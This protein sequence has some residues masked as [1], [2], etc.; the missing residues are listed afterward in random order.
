MPIVTVDPWMELRTHTAARIALG[1]TGVS[2]PTHE[3]LRFGYAHAE[4]RDAVYTPLDE[5][6]LREALEGDGWTTV[7]VHSAA[8]DR[9]TYLARPD[10]GRQLDGPSEE[11]LGKQASSKHEVLLVVGDGLSSA[12]IHR[13]AAPFLRALRKHAPAKFCK[14]PVVIARQAR[15]ALGDAI[16]EKLGAKLVAVL[17]GERP[18]LSSPDSL[19]I[20]LT[21]DPRPD[22]TD[23]DRNCISNVRPE[24]LPHDAAAKRM[25]WLCKEALRLGKTGVELKERSDLLEIEAQA[26]KDDS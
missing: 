18:G 6:A 21:L 26:G 16:G 14:G 15:V 7:T 22:R 19:G 12:A 1:R 20:Y 13:N 4:A 17:I 10:L 9:S 3:V 23:A 5:D 11:A 2:M 25:V 24:G 8:K